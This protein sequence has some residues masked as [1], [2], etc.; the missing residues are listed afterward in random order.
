M[1]VHEGDQI[2]TY[3]PM[4]TLMNSGCLGLDIDTGHVHGNDTRYLRVFL[5]A[6]HRD[7]AAEPAT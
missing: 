2:S 5:R 3:V 1:P 6:L 7:E 4:G